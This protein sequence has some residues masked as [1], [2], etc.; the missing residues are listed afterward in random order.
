M[1]YEELYKFIH[2]KM[3]MTHIYQPIMIKTLL[4]S[5]NNTATV[6]EIAQKFLNQDL[7]QL[8]YYKKIVKKWPHITLVK[9]NKIVKYCK[10]D[11]VYE[12]PLYNVTNKEK[13]KLKELCD[14]RLQEFID[15]GPWIRTMRLI[16][17][18]PISGNMRYDT[19]SKSGGVCVACGKSATVV[20]MDID[21]IVPRSWGGK[22]E[23]TNLQALCYQ[24]NREKRDRD[25]MDFIK[26]QKSLQFRK[27]KCSLCSRTDTITSN[28]L[29]CAME[30]KG[31]ASDMHSLI[32]PNRHVSTFVEL[33]P[34][35][36][37]LCINL[38]HDRIHDIKSRTD[39][40]R[41][42]ISYLEESANDHC[43]I[44]IIPH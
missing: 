29:V 27:H 3:K 32:L 28:H 14:L 11:K 20:P 23:P 4:E 19:L 13:Q 5:K 36:R 6:E 30:A 18:K 2:E 31:S 26:T 33:I 17:S 43:H 7:S 37:Q 24:C 10:K 25:E 41:F 35:E 12:L 39:F 9:N 16:D 44:S 22:T 8:E 42:D 1:E 21:H 38:M 40:K 34:A 15:K